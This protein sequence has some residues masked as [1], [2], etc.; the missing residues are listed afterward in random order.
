MIL[1]VIEVVCGRVGTNC[2]FT[3]DDNIIEI[4]NIV[5]IKTIKIVFSFIIIILIF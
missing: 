1:P 2:G 3:K 5:K 4:N